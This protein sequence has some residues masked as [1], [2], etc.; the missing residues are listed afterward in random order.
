MSSRSGLFLGGDGPHDGPD[1]AETAEA[2]GEPLAD[3]ALEDG[4]LDF[5]V[6]LLEGNE[7]SEPE[8]EEER[9]D[10][11]VFFGGA[12]KFDAIEGSF[13]DFAHSVLLKLK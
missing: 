2:S 10:G 7:E 11:S 5:L 8:A 4:G 1:P 6:L 12:F 13:V 9:D 3:G